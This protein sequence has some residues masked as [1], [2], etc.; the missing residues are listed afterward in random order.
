VFY[1]EKMRKRTWVYTQKPYKYDI[2]C[3]KCS[4]SN[5]DW[6]EYEHK[7][8]CYDCEIDTDGDGGIFDGPVAIGVCEMLGCSLNRYNLKKDRIEYPRIVGNKIKYF[9]KKK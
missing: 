6:S 5:I 9:A 4:G 3:D 7:I 1:E 8:W 2:H